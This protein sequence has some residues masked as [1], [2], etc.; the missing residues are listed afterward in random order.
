MGNNLEIG[1][2]MISRCNILPDWCKIR[3]RFLSIAC[4]YDHAEIALFL[5]SHDGS[6]D[7]TRNVCEFKSMETLD[8]ILSSGKSFDINDCLAFACEFGREKI[9]KMMLKLGATDVEDGLVLA[10]QNNEKEMCELMIK[11]GACN[12]NK[13]V[14]ECLRCSYSSYSK[15]IEIPEIRDAF[16]NYLE[17]DESEGEYE[18]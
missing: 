1:K 6:Y 3:N 2:L 15:T 11:H 8:M 14:K 7:G 5:W 4:R 12:W 13:V 10:C 18:G 9:A 17:I 16:D